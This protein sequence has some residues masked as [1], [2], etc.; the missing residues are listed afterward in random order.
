M[1]KLDVKGLNNNLVFVFSH[2]TREE[3]QYLL[4]EKLDSNPMLFKG[5]P[6]LFQGEGLQRLAPEEINE[7]QRICL[8]YGMHF[9]NPGSIENKPASQSVKSQMS[10]PSGSNGDLI[11]YKTLRSGQKVH[12]AGSVIVWGDVHESAEITA[13]GDVIVLGKLE[14]IAHAGCYGNNKA[15]IFALNLLPRQLRISDRIS[16]SSEEFE[17]TTYPEIAYATDDNICIKEYSSDI[18]RGRFS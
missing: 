15:Y 6:I 17:K 8:D 18:S 13:G 3:L 1:A 9:V 16:R 10:K 7:L 11:V 5:S 4:Q 14:G 2:G 12:S